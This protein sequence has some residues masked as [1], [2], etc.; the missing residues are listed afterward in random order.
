[1]G[2]FYITKISRNLMTP[3]QL[4]QKNQVIL[5]VKNKAGE[6]VSKISRI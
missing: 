4:E 3:I 1:M 6:I 5:V 2:K